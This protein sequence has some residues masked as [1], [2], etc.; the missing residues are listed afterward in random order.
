MQTKLKLA[1]A[2]V[3][4]VFVAGCGEDPPGQYRLAAHEAYERLVQADFKD[5]M[6]DRQCGIL[7]HIGRESTPETSVTWTITSSGR[8]M[9]KF[10]AALTPLDAD[11]T[12]VTVAVAKDKNGHEAYDG[13]Q[14]YRRP[15][16]KQPVRPAIEEQIAA[17]LTGRAYD[18]GNLAPAAVS[19]DG[20]FRVASGDRVCD[21][22]RGRLEEG[23]PFSVDDE[24]SA[25]E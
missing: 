22:Q 5:F 15:A 8:S 3:I 1:M 13:T 9:L 23:Q 11:R 19:A 7:I 24:T 21:I 14:T 17:I 16:V 6:R 20:T 12:Q 10:K 18:E 2:G 25:N 4:S